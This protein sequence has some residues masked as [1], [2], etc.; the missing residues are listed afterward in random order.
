[1][2]IVSVPLG[3]G[4]RSSGTLRRWQRS[5]SITYRK[6]TTVARLLIHLPDELARRFKRAV[7]SRQRSR[8]V[9][10]LLK[11][12]LPGSDDDPIYQAALTVERDEAFNKEMA[13]FEEA[14]IGDGLKHLP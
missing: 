7:P 4:T 9:Q 8:F 5:V 10:D 2:G 1:M 6:E 12:A 13:D 3:R 11:A 14:A